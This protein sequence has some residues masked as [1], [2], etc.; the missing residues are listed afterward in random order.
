MAPRSILVTRPHP[1]AERTAAGLAALGLEPIVAPML[2][3]RFTGADLPDA[4]PFAALAVTSA[5][6]VRA[7]AA[8]PQGER[9][10]NLP[11][12]AVGD[13]TAAE[14]RAV[15]FERISAAGGTLDDL[16]AIILADKPAGPIFYPAPLHQSGDLAGRLAEAGIEVETRILYQMCA[17]TVL[18]PGLDQRLIDGAIAGAVF[19]SRRTA[20]IFAGL[21]SGSQYEQVRRSLSCLCLSEKVAE[22]LVDAHFPRIGLADAPSQEAMMTLALAFSQDQI[23]P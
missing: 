2:E 19:Y 8:H 6:G 20:E 5:N 15:G 21:V 3:A 23:S 16:C 10:A 1:D 22:P 9:F 18:P 7:L 13:H 14:A 17:A 4:A 12:Y 11:V